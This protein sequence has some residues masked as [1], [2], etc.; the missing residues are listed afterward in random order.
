MIGLTAVT[1]VPRHLPTVLLQIAL[2]VRYLHQ[3]QGG[4]EQSRVLEGLKNGGIQ[5]FCIGILTAIAIACAESEEDIATL[6][7]I[8]LR[9]AVCVGAYV[10]YDGCFARPPNK[11]ACLAVRCRDGDLG[12]EGIAIVIQ[13]YPHVSNSS[14][15]VE[16]T[17]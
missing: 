12:K 17:G 14:L 9:L 7:A 2:Y 4:E 10:D 5:G 3:L 8:G 15:T 1:A 13:S 6:G 16:F 11:T